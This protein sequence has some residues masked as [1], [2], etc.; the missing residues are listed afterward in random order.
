MTFIHLVLDS[1][2]EMSLKDRECMRRTDSTTGID[3]IGM[4]RDTPIP[5]QLDKFWASQENKRNLQLLVR[6]IVYKRAYGNATA[7]ATIIASSLVSDDE[8]LPAKSAG[9]EEIPDLLNWIEEADARL[10]V[11]VDWAVRVKQCK[12]IVIVSNKGSRV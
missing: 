5:Q 6:D 9:G 3:I 10:V 1:Y 11:H 2:I 12:R 4:N 7:I 8:A